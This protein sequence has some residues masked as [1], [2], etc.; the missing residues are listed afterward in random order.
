[1]TVSRLPTRLLDLKSGGEQRVKFVT[2]D[3]LETSSIWYAI[4]SHCWGTKPFLILEESTQPQFQHGLSVSSLPK[5]FRDAIQAAR[6]LGMN[7]LWIDSLCITQDSKK[8]WERELAVMG[9]IYCGA[10]IN[11]AATGS[12][13]GEGGLFHN[14]N[15]LKV[16]PCLIQLCVDNVQARFVVEADKAIERE[17][18]EQSPLLSRAWV[19]QERLLAPRVLHFAQEQMIWE[20]KE[21]AACETF[22]GGFS[23]AGDVNLLDKFEGT[24]HKQS[25]TKTGQYHALQRWWAI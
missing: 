22:L 3:Q 11:I 25:Y 7:Y 17:N 1:M 6:N 24:W 18:I 23:A 19:L 8:D 5:T 13:D 14:R 20:C 21:M 10:H 16:Q 9:D 4:L 15:V 2:T 12:S